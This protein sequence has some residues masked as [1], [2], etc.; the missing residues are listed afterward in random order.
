MSVKSNS[1]GSIAD[2]APDAMSRFDESPDADTPSH[3][4]AWVVIRLYISSE[5]SAY[6]TL[7]SHPVSVSNGVIQSYC[8]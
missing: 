8:S 1:A 7:T 5:L 3:C 6:L 4:P 2:T